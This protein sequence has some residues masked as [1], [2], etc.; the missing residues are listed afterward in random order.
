MA[1]GNGMKKK[2]AKRWLKRNSWK[3]AKMKEGL[4]PTEKGNF[5]K[6]KELCEKTLQQE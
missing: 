3:I 2:T 4:G 5:A 1:K 6:Q